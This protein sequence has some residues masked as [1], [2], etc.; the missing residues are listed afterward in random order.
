MHP[1]I[2][3]ATARLTGAAPPAGVLADGAWNGC[4]VLGAAVPA[5]AVDAAGGIP[6]LAAVRA[7]LLLND[8]EAAA[9][10][11]ANVLGNPVTALVRRAERVQLSCLRNVTAQPL[12]TWMVNAL[13]G[14]GHTLRAGQV[15]MTGA[16]A[17]HKV[18]A[19]GETLTAR[20]DGLGAEPLRVSVKLA[21]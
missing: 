21:A 16:A 7:A 9:N 15:V 20:F 1:A 3:L 4:F 10:T 13:S 12:Q 6:S 19:A 2:E 8:V 17:A 18:V 5:A 14:A 11:G